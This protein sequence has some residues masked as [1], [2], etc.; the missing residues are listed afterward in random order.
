MLQGLCCGCNTAITLKTLFNSTNFLLF[1]DLIILCNRWLNVSWHYFKTRLHCAVI[2]LN[3]NLR[4]VWIYVVFGH[5]LHIFC[6]MLAG[7]VF[8]QIYSA[9]TKK[10]QR[11]KREDTY[12][13]DFFFPWKNKDG[14]LYILHRQSWGGWWSNDVMRY[15]TLSSPEWCQHYIKQ[16]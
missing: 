9:A 11:K 7:N 8:F 3:S 2:K 4:L 1:D 15:W 13:F 12:I 16:P 14:D 10:P 5:L 6:E